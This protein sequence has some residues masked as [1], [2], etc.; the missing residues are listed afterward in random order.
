MYQVATSSNSGEIAAKMPTLAS[1]KHAL[2]QRIKKLILKLPQSHGE[3]YFGGE[4]VITAKRERFLLE[5]GDD[6]LTIFVTRESL[7]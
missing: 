3:V 6:G 4:W 5:D 2:Y 7:Q 1:M